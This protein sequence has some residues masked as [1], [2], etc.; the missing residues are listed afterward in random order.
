MRVC[1]ITF[2]CQMNKLDSELAAEALAAAGH[3]V[4][5]DVAQADAVIFNTCAV[6]EHA[7]QRVRSR[8]AQIKSRKE[9]QPGF[10]I[11]VMGCF[12][13]RLGSALLAEYPYVDL[14]CGTR[15]FPRL[16]ELLAQ[17][18]Q[19]PVVAVGAGDD[20][21]PGIGVSHPRRRHQG[22]IGYISVLRGCENCCAY[23]VVPA[24]RG[25]QVSRPRQAIA[26]E[27]RNLAA[28][29]CREIVLLGQNIDAYGKD[30][31]AGEDLA[32]LLETVHEATAGSGAPGLPR[33]RFVTNHPRDIVPRLVQ[34]VNDLPRVCKHFHMPAQSGSTRILAAMR[35]GYTREEYDERLAMIANFCPAA[36][37]ASDFI[38]GFPGET[39]E[40]FQQT[41]DLV[42][43]ARFQNSYIFK[44]S[45]RPGTAAAACADDVPYAEKQRR[46]QALLR[47]QG[48]VSQQ[49]HQALVGSVQE[50]LVEGTSPR[51]QQRLIG[52]TSQNLICVFPAPPH[53]QDYIGRLVKLRIV[54]ATALTLSG[55]LCEYCV[56]SAASSSATTCVNPPAIPPNAAG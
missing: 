23:C 15:H 38:V 16:A 51:D 3:S 33:I 39:E 42:S 20:L 4:V 54:S 27:A 7:E 35:R 19:G 14:V 46:H 48:E 47:A 17:C 45:P 41:L 49:R 6:R 5:A 30:L 55:V 37:V 31:G 13:E 22:V 44:Y 12:A 40:D 10:R 26:E 1:L 36:L 53:R 9:R 32:S 8:L 43:R 2:G 56:H 34:M 28:R 52:R 21:A 50:I 18:A 29:G 24:V 25:A 11:G